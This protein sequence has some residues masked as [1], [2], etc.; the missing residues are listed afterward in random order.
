MRLIKFLRRKSYIIITAAVR[1]ALTAV[2]AAIIAAVFVSAAYDIREYYAV[3]GE[4]IVIIALT[5][6]WW[7]LTGYAAR[8]WWHDRLG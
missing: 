7:K 6:A 2:F 4:W 5:V 3:G 8:I 1:I